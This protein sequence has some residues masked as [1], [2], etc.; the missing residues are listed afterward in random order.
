MQHKVTGQTVFNIQICSEGSYDEALKWVRIHS[1]SGTR[2]NWVKDERPE[3]APVKCADFPNRYH[4]IF[5]C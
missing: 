3:M 2:N 4:Y 5:R 1:P